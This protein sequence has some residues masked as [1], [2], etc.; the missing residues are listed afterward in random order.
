MDTMQKNQKVKAAA[1]SSAYGRRRHPNPGVLRLLRGAMYVL[2]GGITV[3]ALLLLILPSFRL[4]TIEVEGNT[5][6]TDEQIIAAA[7]LSVGQ[8]TLGIGSYGELR[9]KIWS[10]DTARYIDEIKFV[11]GFTSLKILVTEPSRVMYTEQNGV[12]YVM[13]DNLFVL[14]ATDDAQ[15][16]A[17]FVRVELPANT[18][19]EAGKCAAFAYEAPDTGY[20][21]ELLQ[22]MEKNDLW[23]RVTSIDFSKK[24]SVSYVLQDTCRVQLGKVSNLETKLALVDEIL[25]RRGD[26]GSSFS[27][28]D[29]SDTAKPTYR[30]LSAGAI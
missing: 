8:E 23:D 7:G 26:Q 30:P 4:K 28:V 17:N 24:F 13:D 9:E 2:M 18:K 5:F 27:V 29:V 22:V 15:S 19:L 10:W 12:Y 21:D 6:Y 3:L 20:I 1:H 14:H 16:V 11:R 25:A